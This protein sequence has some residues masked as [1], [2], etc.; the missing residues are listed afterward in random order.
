[1]DKVRLGV[2]GCGGMARNHMKE[3]ANVTRVELVAGADPFK[4]NV[5]IAQRE[6]GIKPF[7]DGRKLIKS[8]LCDAVLVATPHYFHPVY[9]IAALKAG[10]HALSEKPVAVTAKAAQ[11][12]NDE[13]AKHPG[14][15]FGVMYQMR[16]SAKIRRAKQIIS[17]GELGEI[18]RVHWTATDWFRTQAYYDS[19]SWRATWKGEGG[20]VLLNQ[21]PHNLDVL[22]WLTGLPSRVTA[23]IGLGKFHKIEVEDDVTAMLEWPNG[24]TGVFIT[25]TG[26]APGTN[27]F[28]I[29]GDRGRLVI[30]GNFLEFTK[31]EES[32]REYCKTNAGR[33]STPKSNVIREEFP[34]QVLH[35]ELMQAFIDAI[36]DRKPPA[37]PGVEGIWSV[38]LANAMIMSGIKGKTV[39]LP[40]DRNGYDRMLKKLIKE[41]DQ[42]KAAT[43]AV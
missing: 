28:E 35:R 33:M 36:L 13:A 3:L 17:S 21:C 32:V 31:T 40:M 43:A 15:V 27:Y 38:E 42:R 23:R 9:T 6:F 18:Q 4:E 7:D 20:G 29:I 34:N 1:M 11:E 14:L 2:I 41:S 22:C 37:A 26:E 19:G 12:M 30:G 10:L 8:G 39:D 16:T 25:T 5:E 24:A